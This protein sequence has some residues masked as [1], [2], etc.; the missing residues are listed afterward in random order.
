MAGAALADDAGTPAE[1]LDRAS[2]MTDNLAYQP[3]F[4]PFKGDV[5]GWVKSLPEGHSSFGNPF[6]YGA[7]LRDIYT[8]EL[9]RFCAV[10]L[11][12]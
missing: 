12:R 5:R 11:T 7:V 2:G 9:G 3:F 4:S 10:D 1:V 8:Q 6:E